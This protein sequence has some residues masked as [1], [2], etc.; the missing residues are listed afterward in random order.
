MQGLVCNVSD[1]LTL[2]HN[3]SAPLVKRAVVAP[4]HSSSQIQTN[5]WKFRH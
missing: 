3:V 5:F 1:T 2:H 4:V